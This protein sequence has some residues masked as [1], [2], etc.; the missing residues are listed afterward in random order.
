MYGTVAKLITKPGA[1]EEI[2]RMESGRRPSGYIGSYVFQS[3]QDANELWLVVIF[4]SKETYLANADSP[5]QD[6]EFRRLMNYLVTEPEWH[7]GEIVF[8]SK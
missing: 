8:S 6:A 5:E 2:R 3:D 4:E 7:D 1:I